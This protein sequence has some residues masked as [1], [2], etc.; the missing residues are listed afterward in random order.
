V[1]VKI[2]DIHTIMENPMIIMGTLRIMDAPMTKAMPTNMDLLAHMDIRPHH[3]NMATHM[4]ADPAQDTAM[5]SRASRAMGIRMNM[6]TRMAQAKPAPT[7]LACLRSHR[8][9]EWL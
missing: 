1:A 6:D 2:M 5:V 4:A 8:T 7:P 9:R 3:N